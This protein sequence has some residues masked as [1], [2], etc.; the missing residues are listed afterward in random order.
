MTIQDPNLHSASSSGDQSGD[1]S[2][3]DKS[4]EESNSRALDDTMIGV[5]IES[6]PPAAPAASAPSS[7]GEMPEF[8]GRYQIQQ[9]LGSGGYG[10]VYQ[11]YDIT[12]RRKVAIKVPRLAIDRPD[13][14][15]DFL[16]EARQLAQLKHPGIVTV[17]DVVVDGRECYIVSDFLEG[18]SLSRFM[19]RAP[20]TWRDAATICMKL[21]DALAHAH[22]NRTIHRDLKPAN[23]IMADGSRPVIVD[24]GLAVSDAQRASGTGL[25]EISG[26]PAFMSPE[27]AA[28]AGHRIDGRTD[29]Y[30]LGVIL[31]RIVTGRLPFETRDTVELLRQVR[32][33]EPQPPRQLVRNL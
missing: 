33:D 26:T 7:K 28:G 25:G 17:F 18:Q 27:Q 9:I 4:R 30:S 5:P 3:L 31:Y 8:I 15:E 32:D 20:L 22:S 13:V 24:F 11:G 10:V 2:Q 14:L 16:S 21:A 29:I 12:L 23:I 6:P 1:S 19:R